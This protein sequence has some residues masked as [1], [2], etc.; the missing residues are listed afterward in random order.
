MSVTD[1]MAGRG[2]AAEN[3]AAY[4]RALEQ[5]I[6]KA[7]E[8]IE[9][10]CVHIEDHFERLEFLNAWRAGDEPALAEW[11]EYPAKVRGK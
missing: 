11:P 8:A 5:R 3:V 9:F 10:A 1:D 7:A 4:A 6:G 2:F